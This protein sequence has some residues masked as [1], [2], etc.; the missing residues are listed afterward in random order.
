MRSFDGYTNV[1][2]EG[3]M[4]RLLL[5]SQR[6]NSIAV[7][8]IVVK[9]K[10][11][12]IPVGLIL[13]RGD[14]ISTISSRPKDPHIRKGLQQV[15]LEEI[16]QEYTVFFCFLINQFILILFIKDEREKERKHQAALRAH[17]AEKHLLYEGQFDESWAT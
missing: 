13:L 9:D 8:R 4:F 16:I 10:Y 11:S 7:E 15:P 6:F 1:L 14:V 12:D 2:L 5:L 3:G 17:L